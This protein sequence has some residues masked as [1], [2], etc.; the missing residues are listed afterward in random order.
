[1]QKLNIALL[2]IELAICLTLFLGY[3]IAFGGGETDILFFG[4]FYS[5]VSIHL[6]WTIR[7]TKTSKKFVLHFSVFRMKKI[8]Q[9][10]PK[11]YL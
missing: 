3:K 5:G 2:I 11:L 9:Q 7:L 8:E 6:V 4:L 10:C 1:M